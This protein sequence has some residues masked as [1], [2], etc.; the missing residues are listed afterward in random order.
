V[1]AATA[2]AGL[3]AQVINFGHVGDGNLHYNVLL[4]AGLA[5]TAVK[6]NTL[7]LNRVVHD[8]VA[9]YEGSISAEHGVGQLRRDELRRY[10]SPVEMDLM[11]AI[12][13]ALDPNLIMNPGKLL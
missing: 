7:R 13:R 6:E 9:H 11:L 1:H 12:K 2:A 3:A 10:K 5:P 8:L 4:P